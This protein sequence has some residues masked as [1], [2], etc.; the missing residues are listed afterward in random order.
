M[1]AL[2]NLSFQQYRDVN[3]RAYAGAIAAFYN[4]DTTTPRVV[5]R[6]NDLST[7]WGS[8]VTADASGMFPGV[9]LDTGTFNFRITSAT[10]VQLAAGGPI[11]PAPSTNSGGGGGSP[12]DPTT[13][14]QTGDAMFL[15]LAGTRTGWVRDN[16]R[17]IGNASSG[18]T[19]RA[20]ADCAALF[21]WYWNNFPDSIC[22]VSGGRGAT[23]AADFAANKTIGTLDKRGR[24]AI[25]LDDMG[26][27][28]AY[29]LQVA[30]TINTTNASTSATV[31][32]ATGLA[33][34]MFV[35]AS[36]VPAGTTVT[37]ISGTSVILSNAATA[38]ASGVAVRFSFIT[39]PQVAGASGG[40]GAVTLTV[41]GL[42][43]H[44]HTGTTDTAGDHTHQVAIGN[45]NIPGGAAQAGP[46]SNST[47]TS[48]AGAHTHTFTTAATGA[49][50]PHSNLSPVVAGTWLRKL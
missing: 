13:I 31:A 18:A 49:S 46:Q 43:S 21:A 41:D 37:A 19:E 33:I 22:P 23:A 39:D 40:E 32:S 2:W 20:N 44:T 6:D 17:T 27:S 25:G 11:D 7:P 1:A 28:P 34:G 4:G 16:G 26:N 12:V 15:E 50:R 24:G 14:F 9:F 36:G 42:P 30:T 3:G 5:Y 48:L 29:R 45:N 38:T 47:P 8:T 10:G 35:I